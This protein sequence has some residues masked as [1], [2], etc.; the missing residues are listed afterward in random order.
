M[1]RMEV[2]EEIARA[3]ERVRAAR[4]AGLRIGLVPTMGA[5][6]EGHL[7]LIR[8]AR[9]K[10]PFVV[11]TI[12]VNPRQF[13]PAEDLAGYP[14]RLDADLEACRREGADLVFTPAAEAIYPAGFA[15]TVH[16]VG[17]TESLCG[18]HR[19]GHFDGVTTVV[20][21]LFRILPA[22]EA[23]FGEKDYQQLVVVRRMARDLDI[24]IEITGCPTVREADGLAMSSR[25]AYLTS[26]E[27]RQ[28]TTLSA[29]LFEVRER[30]SAGERC[31]DSLV[32]GMRERISVGGP[33]RI[34]YVEI[35]DAE[36][37]RPLSELDRAARACV[38]VRLGD[39]RLIDNVALAP[40]AGSAPGASGDGSRE[41]S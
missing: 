14:R 18:R 29:A 13:G 20:A 41:I 32:R 8:V 4:A 34:D 9:R 26:D 35:V 24:P 23:F 6:H 10:C 28:A 31:V 12:F 21:K 7:S 30:A 11:V 37:L 17:A 33:F 19:P 36:T 3:R 22:D 39:C 40:P 16:V 15:T 38:A 25:N 2:I 1:D 27:R 5:L